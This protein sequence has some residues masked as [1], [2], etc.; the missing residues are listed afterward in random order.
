MPDTPPPTPAQPSSPRAGNGNPLLELGITVLLPAIVLM[1]LS[2]QNRLG[3]AGALV[4]ALAFPIGWGLREAFTRRK[5]SP[6]AVLGVVSTLLTGGI[7]LLKVDPYWLAVK[8]AAVPGLIGLAVLGS[9]WTRWPLIRIFVFNRQIFDVERVEAALAS[10]GTTVPFEL[11]LRRCTLL[12]SLTFFFSSVMNFVL[13]R[14]VVTS[15]AGT[16]AFNEELGRLTLLSYPVIALPS[17]VMMMA[18]MW[19]L[20]RGARELTGLHL[21]DMLRQ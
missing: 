16:E 21:T 5:L 18:L 17:M 2:A 9:N 11:R 4:L 19:W 20:A 1:Q 15:P 10:R 12:L 14:W 7:G 6:M 8:E 3:P 13:A